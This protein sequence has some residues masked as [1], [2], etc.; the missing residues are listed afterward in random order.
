M[1]GPRRAAF[2]GAVHVE[3]LEG[4]IDTLDGALPPLKNFILPVMNE[5]TH[6]L[7]CLGCTATVYVFPCNI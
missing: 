7:T 4:W 2:D 3:E 1:V 6:D 5:R